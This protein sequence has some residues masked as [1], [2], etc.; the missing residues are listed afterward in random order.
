[1]SWFKNLIGKKEEGLKPGDWVN[2][3]SKGV[4]RIERFVDEYFDESNKHT[5]TED[6]KIGDKHPQRTVVLKRFLN[7]KFQKS[8]S[9][10]TCS[11]YFISPLTAE[12]KAGL[13]KV[14]KENPS[15]IE[16]L[17]D[18]TIP[19][20]ISIHNMDLQI[21]DKE[22][23]EKVNELLTF[24]KQGKTFTEI[25][26]EMRRKDILKLVPESYGNYFFQLFNHDFEYNNKAKVWRD[27]KVLSRKEIN[28]R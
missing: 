21:D 18:Y 28:E 2:S 13:D 3:Y 24:I 23:L 12:Q 27:A 4:F 11:E 1:M 16:A 5:I 19:T 17:N 6:N 8:I 10:E 26:D 7:S 14:L 22:S 9:Y 20:I 15:L 25:K